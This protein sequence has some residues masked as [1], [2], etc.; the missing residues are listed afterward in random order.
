MEHLLEN[1]L[2]RQ[3]QHRF[4]SKKC[5]TINLLEILETMILTVAE[6]EAMD[7]VFLDFSKAFNKVQHTRLMA[8]LGAHGLGGK[9]LKWIGS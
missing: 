4:M 9:V 6:G 1:N 8:E 7:I 2:L 5:C 3:S